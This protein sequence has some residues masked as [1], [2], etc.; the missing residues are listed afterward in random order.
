MYKINSNHINEFWLGYNNIFL[1]FHKFIF[2]ISWIY[3]APIIFISRKIRS[4]ANG[5]LKYIPTAIRGNKMQELSTLW[6]FF[7]IGCHG[8]FLSVPP[9]G[10][11]L[12][13]T[14]NIGM[15]LNRA[16][17]WSFWRDNPIIDSHLV[18]VQVF[19]LSWW[20]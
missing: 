17:L 13:C 20:F 14:L 5:G 11:L 18:Q 3:F 7:N 19:S 16:V 10:F 4:Q 9:R 2:T 8:V 6:V 12:N 1:R 15:I